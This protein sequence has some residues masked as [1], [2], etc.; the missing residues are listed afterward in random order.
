MYSLSL[1]IYYYV[2]DKY[3]YTKV[4]YKYIHIYNSYY[5]VHFKKKIV[6]TRTYVLLNFQTLLKSTEAD[7]RKNLSSKNSED[8]GA[9]SPE[10]KSSGE[11][12]ISSASTTGSTTG[13]L[14]QSSSC[15]SDYNPLIQ[16][17]GLF[18]QILL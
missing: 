5:N 3:S 6:K 18:D 9:S 12:G 14:D 4:H 2:F 1:A 11:S 7:I 15:T 13:S 10:R 16:C 17:P 8:G